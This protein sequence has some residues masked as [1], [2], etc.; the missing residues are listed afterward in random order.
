MSRQIKHGD[1]V[2]VIVWPHNERTGEVTVAVEVDGE[3]T[4][5]VWLDDNNETLG[6]WEGEIEL[7]SDEGIA[8]VL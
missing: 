2:L 4:Y 1:H 5:N 7:L 6:F 8:D 3:M